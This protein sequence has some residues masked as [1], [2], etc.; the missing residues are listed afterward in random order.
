MKSERGAEDTKPAG[1][2][3]LGLKSV[4]N[5]VVACLKQTFCAPS[6]RHDKNFELLVRVCLNFT[7]TTV[8][9]EQMRTCAILVRTRYS[10]LDV[11][12]SALPFFFEKILLQ[13]SCGQQPMTEKRD[14]RDVR[15]LQNRHRYQNNLLIL[16][17]VVSSTNTRPKNS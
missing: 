10:R 3:L 8:Q 9:S 14:Y 15:K 6:G 4:F 13:L 17:I 5:R 16:K 11:R 2:R 12:S 1:F 7:H